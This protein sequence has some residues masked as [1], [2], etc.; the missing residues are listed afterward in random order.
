[1]I[2]N[3]DR[4]IKDTIDSSLSYRF[5]AAA[6]PYAADH[7]ECVLDIWDKYSW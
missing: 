2:P 6:I 1:M 3:N 7:E 4:D 5:S